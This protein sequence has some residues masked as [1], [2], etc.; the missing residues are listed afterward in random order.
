M[1]QGN[2]KCKTKKNF[3]VALVTPKP[4]QIHITIEGP[5]IGITLNKLVITTAAQKLICA[6]TNTYPIKASI[7]NNKYKVKPDTHTIFIR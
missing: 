7:I 2:K 4:L 6:H 1:P 3:K 5:Q